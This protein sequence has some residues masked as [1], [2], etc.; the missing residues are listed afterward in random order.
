LTCGN[1]APRDN[2]GTIEEPAFGAEERI[3]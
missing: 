2:F 1:L 3:T